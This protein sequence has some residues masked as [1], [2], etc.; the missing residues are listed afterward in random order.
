MIEKYI[1]FKMFFE[2]ELP[3]IILGVI[4]GIYL[5]LVIVAKIADEWEKRQQKKSEKYFGKEKEGSE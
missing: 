5:L 4:A 1:E 3:F 2:Y